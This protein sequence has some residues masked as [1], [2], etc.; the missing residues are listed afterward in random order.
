MPRGQQHLISVIHSPENFAV[1]DVRAS[2]A[3]AAVTRDVAT[4]LDYF[5]YHF[6]EPLA[7]LMVD[8]AHLAPMHAACVA[9]R[10]KAIVLCGDSGAG[11][12]SLAYACARQGWTYLS[13]DGTY[14]IRGRSEPWVAGRPFRIRFRESARK[15]FPELER[16]TPTW[17]PNGKLDIE[18]DT[19]ALSLRTSTEKPAGHVVFLDRRE[20]PGRAVFGAYPAA[21]AKQKLEALV[22]YGD[23]R[24]RREQSRALNSLLQLP[25]SRLTYGDPESA[26]RALRA[27]AQSESAVRRAC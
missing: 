26:E 17:R 1:C 25:V 10:D 19:E 21:S 7:Y 27:L 5:Q 13:D 8:A 9:W 24:I 16:F 18:V 23:E 2:F 14:V 12:T 4:N 15:L 11:K 3:F 6:L 20:T 22:V